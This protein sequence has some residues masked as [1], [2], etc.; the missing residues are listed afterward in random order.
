M[1][2]LAVSLLPVSFTFSALSDND[3]RA[4]IQMR[5]KE[6]SGGDPAA[7]HWQPPETA[8]RPGLRRRSCYARATC[9]AQIIG[10]MR[11]TVTQRGVK[12]SRKARVSK[13][14]GSKTVCPVGPG[15]HHLVGSR[16]FHDMRYGRGSADPCSR[17]RTG[18]PLV[19]TWPIW[20]LL[21][22]I[23]AEITPVQRA[24]PISICQDC[25][26]GFAV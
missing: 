22:T 18:Y 5:V 26:P 24:C 13:P 10:Q 1:N 23:V 11:F 3:K 12:L 8:G 21:F 14:V 15:L 20:V 17:H 2:S 19:F 6:V 4:R 16:W 9:A 7:G 25:R